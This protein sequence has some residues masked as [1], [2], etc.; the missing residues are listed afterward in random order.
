MAA[1]V[2]EQIGKVRHDWSLAELQALCL[3]AGANSILHGERLLTTP[4]PDCEH[5]HALFARLGLA[6]EERAAATVAGAAAPAGRTAF[7]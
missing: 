5:D 6:P 7:G 2:A 3:L 1:I 4:N